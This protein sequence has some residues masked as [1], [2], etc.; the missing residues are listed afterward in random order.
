MKREVNYRKFY[1]KNSDQEIDKYKCRV[2]VNHLIRNNVKSS[3]I[4]VTS[5]SNGIV[6]RG[7]S[8]TDV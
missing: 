4:E 2:V 6:I 5:V 8:K 1:K 7:K 3:D